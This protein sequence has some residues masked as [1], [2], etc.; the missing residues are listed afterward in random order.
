MKKTMLLPLMALLILFGITAPVVAEESIDEMDKRC[1]S[2]AVEDGIPA[3]ELEDYVKECIDG[4][5]QEGSDSAQE[6]DSE[7]EQ[8]MNKD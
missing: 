4:I 6:S 5:M 7:S 3:E 2:Y 8:E 1:R